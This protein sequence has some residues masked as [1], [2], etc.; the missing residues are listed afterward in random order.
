MKKI[1]LNATAVVLGLHAASALADLNAVLKGQYRF[2]LSQTCTYSLAGFAQPVEL[3]VLGNAYSA[4]DRG[5]GTIRFNGDGTFTS[6]EQGIYQG[7]GPSQPGWFP[8]VSYD[9]VCGGTYQVNHDLSFSLDADCTISPT[10]GPSAGSTLRVEGITYEGQL[11][12]PRQNFIAA[13]VGATVQP[14]LHSSGTTNQRICAAHM[15]GIKIRSSVGSA[16]SQPAPQPQAAP[17][18]APRPVVRTQ[19]RN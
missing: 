2:N 19:T 14:V 10:S 8:V 13:S 1:I 11:D 9:S 6:T 7:Q 16:P 18:L 12:I 15:A 17:A 3:D 5:K 4:E